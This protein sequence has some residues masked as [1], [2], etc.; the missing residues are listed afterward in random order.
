MISR[1]PTNV[2]VTG[3]NSTCG[4]KIK[5]TWPNIMTNYVLKATNT[6]SPGA[7]W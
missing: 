7:K 5:L 4:G 2:L 1:L 3:W 6:V